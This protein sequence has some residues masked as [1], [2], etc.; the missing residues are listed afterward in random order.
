MITDL[1]FAP[2]GKTVALAGLGGNVQLWDVGTGKLLE[3]LKGHSGAILS[4]AFSPDSRTL[5]SGSTDQTVRLWN[6]ETRR[7]LL[8]LDSGHV[9][10]HEVWSLAFSAD[11]KRLIAG[12]GQGTAF[13]SAAPALWSDPDQAALT[14]RDLLRS[15]ADFQSRIRMFSENLRLH[16]AVAKLDS[17]DPRVQA[18]LAATEANWHASRHAWPEAARAFD[19]LVATDRVEPDAWLRTP[20]LFRLATALFYENRPSEAARL[21]QGVWRRVSQDG[22]PAVSRDEVT[23]HRFIPLRAALEQRLVEN[24]RDRGLIELRAT[25]S[26][27]ELVPLLAKVSAANSTD[28]MLSLQLAALQAWFGQQQ[29]L[30]ATRK[31]ILAFA[32]GTS[33]TSTAERAAKACSLLPVTDQGELETALDLGRMA[34]KLNPKRTWS[35]LAHG[36]SEYRSGNFAAAEE[37]LRPVAE[38]SLSYHRFHS[39]TFYRAMSLFRQ[40]KKDEARQLASAAAAR[41]RP[42]PKDE[43]NPLADDA[44]LEEL[45]L[46]LAYKEA[47]AMIG[48]DAGTPPKAQT[49]KR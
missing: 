20:G 26:G 38:L 19:R 44:D 25:L 3:P 2:D 18:A 21:L 10:F 49:D 4:L 22:F 33:E 34:V 28:T 42:L 5:A 15:N 40:G 41:M 43:N 32:R 27:M 35:R 39:A 16:E 31:R 36:M 46:W 13:W 24:P 17:S 8:Q 29:E 45:I 30:A 9:A 37:A 7:E 12:G 23:G 14:L 6:F 11:G 47:K 1:A 48:F